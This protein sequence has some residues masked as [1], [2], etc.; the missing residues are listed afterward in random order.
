MILESLYHYA[1]SHDLLNDDERAFQKKKIHW[2]INLNEQGEFVGLVSGEE[3]EEGFD[4]PYS[5]A[6]KSQG[7]VADFLVD[8]VTAVFGID[9]D[10]KERSEKQKV[11]REENNRKKFN[12]F[13]K[14]IEVAAEATGSPLLTSVARFRPSFN[15]GN[16]FLRY[17]PQKAAG[18]NDPTNNASTYL[19]GLPS[20]SSSHTLPASPTETEEAGPE[21]W[22]IRQP[23]GGER[24][25]KSD[26]TFSFSVS[27]TKVVDDKA[28]K[29]YWLGEF[30]KEVEKDRSG[31]PVG[32]CS[33]TGKQDQPLALTHMPKIKRVPSTQS[34]G[35]A[36]ASCDKKAFTSYGFEQSLNMATS[37]EAS[38][39]YCRALN[40]MLE[41]G[42]RSYLTLGSAVCCFW[43]KDP[44]N[45]MV[46]S[47]SRIFESAIPAEIQT[48]L[49]SPY[50]AKENL[51]T[52][53]DR[54]YALVLAGNAGRIMIRHWMDLPLGEARKNFECWFEDL[55]LDALMEQATNSPLALRELA[56]ATVRDSKD[57]R[58]EVVSQLFTAAFRGSAPSMSLLQPLL[59]RLSIIVAESGHLRFDHSRFALLRLIINRNL[60]IYPKENVMEVPSSL[61][62]TSKDPGYLCGR[63]LAVLSRAQKKAHGYKTLSAGLTERYFGTAMTSPQSVFPLLLRGNRHHLSKLEKSDPQGLADDYIERDIA[64]IVQ[65]LSDFPRT[66]DLKG[67]GRFALGFYQEQAAEQA[68]IR[69][70]LDNKKK[71]T[72]TTAATEN[73]KQFV[74]QSESQ[75]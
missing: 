39:G 47:L 44:K 24:K 17:G 22:W 26:Q 3:K 42:S 23:D 69:A 43:S 66:L 29:D 52:E 12:D 57:L 51:S 53:T 13:W 58:T 59:A 74:E 16:E 67:Q 71:Q 31:A 65:H 50:T 28:M 30:R 56:K 75:F 68:K 11:R 38:T 40:H 35:A 36:I 72:E 18:S 73:S 7:G 48:F 19:D 55:K 45:P 41:K 1:Q 32:L 70:Y 2:F 20:D 63:L 8:R 54:F 6:E 15:S 34:F 33:I 46:A 25:L 27:L 9:L 49:K 14:Q 37:V 60:R 5:I 4:S 10:Q 62:E 64:E 61:D 21:G